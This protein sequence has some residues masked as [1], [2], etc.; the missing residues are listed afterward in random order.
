MEIVALAA[1][2][3][4]DFEINR[5]GR[6]S[7][8]KVVDIIEKN[9][10]H[11]P[12]HDQWFTS[13]VKQR[14]AD[15]AIPV[16]SCNLNKT[17]GKCP[18]KAEELAIHS[19]KIVADPGMHYNIV[20]D[21]HVFSDLVGSDD[22]AVDSYGGMFWEMAHNLYPGLWSIQLRLSSRPMQRMP[23]ER[24]LFGCD[25]STVTKVHPRGLARHKS[26]KDLPSKSKLCS[27]VGFLM[28]LW[29]WNGSYS[30]HGGVALP[31]AAAH[32]HPPASKQWHN[33][34]VELEDG[35]FM[36]LHSKIIREF[37]RTPRLSQ[38][39][40]LKR[41]G[42]LVRVFEE[43]SR[44]RAWFVATPV[45]V[46]RANE[47]CIKQ[48]KC[49]AQH[50]HRIVFGYGLGNGTK[51]FGATYTRSSLLRAKTLAVFKLD[52]G[53]WSPRLFQSLI[54]AAGDVYLWKL[55]CR[56]FGDRVAKWTMFCQLVNWSRYLLHEVLPIGYAKEAC[57]M[58]KTLTFA[59]NFQWFLAG[60]VAWIL[61][62]YSLLGHK[63]FRFVLPALPLAMLFAGN[64]LASIESGRFAN[65][66]LSDGGK[67][68]ASRFMEDPPTGACP[69]TSSF[70]NPWRTNSG[71]FWKHAP[72][73]WQA[74]LLPRTSTDPGLARTCASGHRQLP[75]T[76]VC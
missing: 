34:V 29:N 61:F 68:E 58:L 30:A 44:S 67:D 13:G 3:T 42:Y 15:K 17:L 57:S 60:L 51:V 16:K 39:L 63:E 47:Q 49:D 48:Q 10:I 76:P 38:Q 55:A 21:G 19:M 37:G 11:F 35:K 8:S 54:A 73:S 69:V 28:I 6:P 62:T 31:V 5:G 32:L 33:A 71:H 23:G 24:S 74:S 12:K 25:E 26:C 27:Q 52:T 59:S 56:A 1:S 7:P 14:F 43:G 22:A 66:I 70:F 9:Y 50:P 4:F 45:L 64:S 65:E 20:S 75:Q 53:S 18:D 46:V 40:L 72:T 2:T 41:D 36:L